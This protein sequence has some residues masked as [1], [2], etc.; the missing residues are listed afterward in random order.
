MKNRIFLIAALMLFVIAKSVEA[1]SS[2]NDAGL[3]VTSDDLL[4]SNHKQLVFVVAKNIPG[5]T[6]LKLSTYNNDGVTHQFRSLIFP[7][8]LQRGQVIPLW[9]G[10]FNDFFA[11]P[12]LGFWVQILTSQGNTY[13]CH[14]MFPVNHWEQYKEP[15]ITSISETGG[16]TS[17]Y[18]IT[19]RGI[20]DTTI[21]S[22]ILINTEMFV[23]PKTVQQIAPA[24]IKFSVDATTPN[25]FPRGKYLLTL[26][27]AGHCDTMMGR[28]R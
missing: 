21:P 6:T 3:I 20:F 19:I 28:H 23:P 8:G 10:E 2:G 1:Q 24:V 26:C 25:I 5:P 11:T 16:Y 18:E 22:L 15:M 14:T 9:K 12:W 4:S 27:Q 13:W 17:P 7:I